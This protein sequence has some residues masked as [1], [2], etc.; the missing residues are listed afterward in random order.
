MTDG[1]PPP[2][3]EGMGVVFE[4][5]WLELREPADIEARD[6]DLLE[7]AAALLDDPESV[8]LD[9]GCGTGATVRAL[10]PLL[11]RPVRWRLVDNDPVLLSA[12]AAALSGEQVETVPLDIAQLKD[13]PLTGV[14]LVTASAL[15]DLCSASFVGEFANHL[16]ERRLG[17]YAALN[18]DGAIVWEPPHRCDTRMVELFNTHQR[19]D[20]G[21]G[22]ALGS[23]AARVL[24]SAFARLGYGVTIARSPWQLSGRSKT[25]QAALIEG[26]V[27]AVGELH[28]VEPSALRAWRRSRLGA[29]SAGAS[30]RVGHLDV[31]VNPPPSSSSV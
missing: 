11:R 17:L 22:P 7:K 3:V 23:D 25:L 10:S 16:A 27:T 19:T 5:T 24:A 14:S 4:R 6:A 2:R 13:L 30:C 9:L 8:V 1:L 29:L 12:A 28:V 18:Y 20:K 26:V 21:L 15:F 31:L